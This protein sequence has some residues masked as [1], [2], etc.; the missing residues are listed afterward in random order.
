MRS[1]DRNH[2]EA[3]VTVFA[4]LCCSSA[5]KESWRTFACVLLLA[6]Q[7]Y[8]KSWMQLAR[9][10][11]IHKKIG[12]TYKTDALKLWH[13][14]N[15]DKLDPEWLVSA[16]TFFQHVRV[17]GVSR[18]AQWALIQWEKNVLQLRIWHGLPKPEEVMRLQA[19]GQR[20]ISL[21]YPDFLNPTWKL[22][23]RAPLD[24]LVHDLEHCER[25]HCSERMHRGQK[26][27]FQF[28][29]KVFEHPALVRIRSTAQLAR[30]FDYLMSDMNTH[31]VH[32]F[33]C[34]ESLVIRSVL[35]AHGKMDNQKLDEK[36][37]RVVTEI[38]SD[39][40]SHVGGDQ[41]RVY[42]LKRGRKEQEDLESFFIQFDRDNMSNQKPATSVIL[43]LSG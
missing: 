24:F 31:C 14:L 26:G 13:H 8:G 12:G 7:Q 29:I 22:Q 32:L 42:Q 15:S 6:R 16:E 27:F 34:L 33:S 18:R 30:E 28:L 3:L 23:G 25:L 19:R 17:R 21:L 43:D 35:R 36:D 2:S 39:L 1:V 11:D 38:L 10:V 20:M 5:Q 40:F 37:E 4:E 41:E 9:R